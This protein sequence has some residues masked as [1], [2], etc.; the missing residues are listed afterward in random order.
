MTEVLFGV[1]TLGKEP[2]ISVYR[3]I[4]FDNGREGL[5]CVHKSASISDTALSIP[6]KLLESEHYQ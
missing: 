4:A 2:L 6:K 1:I 3:W 5:H